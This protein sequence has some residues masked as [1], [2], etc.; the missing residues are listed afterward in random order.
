MLIGSDDE[1]PNQRNA[2]RNTHNFNV[3][4]WIAIKFWMRNHPKDNTEKSIVF[5]N[6]DTF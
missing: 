3:D 1:R 2:K 4:S 6:V 5:V